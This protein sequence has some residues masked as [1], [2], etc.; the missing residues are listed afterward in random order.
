MTLENAGAA[1]AA[2][3]PAAPGTPGLAA[4]LVALGL[5]RAVLAHHRPLDEAL[6]A[7]SGLAALAPRDRAFARLLAT[8]VLRRQG[9]FD[10][11][12][13]GVLEQKLPRAAVVVRDVLRLGL[14]QILVL[15]TPAHAAVA[16]SVALAEAAGLAPHKGLVNAVLRR[17]VQEGPA[18][19]AAQDA[20]RLNTPD[21]LW[22]SWIESHGEAAARA[23]AVA[24][25]AEPPLDLTVKGDPAEWAER[26]G[27][28]VLPTGSL[29]RAAS[30]GRVTELPGWDEGAWW[31]QD[32]AAALPARLLGAGPG[33]RVADLCAA[34][35][36][37]T[38]QLAATGAEVTAV[39]RAESRLDRLRGTLA[40]LGLSATLVAADVA[41]WQPEGTGG[42]GAGGE[43]VFDAVLLDP[44]CSSTGTIRRHP[45]IPRLKHPEDV[46]KLAAVQARLL[47]RAVTLV[48]PG[49]RLVWCTCSLQ[50]EEGE[51]RIAAL[52]DSG[53][54]V[55]REPITADEVGGVAELITPLGEVRTLPCHRPDLGG[56]DGFHIARLRRVG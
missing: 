22:Q 47:D 30:G 38:A 42:E 15:G 45:D 26:L 5:L 23:I 28:T 52:L 14:A 13:R 29:R 51:A 35:G 50:P 3:S 8:T 4:R 40:R 39:D 34:P 55:R 43:G 21:W 48:R 17:L 12:I 49:G 11:L 32:A 1:E 25:L 19:F 54:P 44:P 7:D 10:A 31:V 20:A 41:T 2:P 53:A 27:A 18:Q 37:K 9:Q 24:H 36:G 46:A 56:F 16:T 6:E 33:L